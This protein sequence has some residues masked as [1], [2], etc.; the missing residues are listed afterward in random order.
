MS[1]RLVLALIAS[2]AALLGAAGSAS[3]QSNP[4]EP[5]GYLSQPFDPLPYLPPPPA[6]GSAAEAADVAAYRDALKYVGTERWAQAAADDPV[7]P[8]DVL[9]RYRCAIGV[10]LAPEDAPALVRAITRSYR[11]ADAAIRAAK[12]KYARPRPFKA[13]AAD[14][15]L[16][17]PLTETQRMNASPSYPSGHGSYGGLWGLMLMELAP[18]RAPQVM[19]RTLTFAE[20][21]V[22]CRVHYPSD[23]Q[24]A[25]LVAV[26]LYARLQAEPEF[27]ADMAEARREVDAARAAQAGTPEG[28]PTT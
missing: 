26:G 19:A 7:K 14:T 10:D 27:R 25:Q 16:C 21:R 17:L 6:A 3:T 18:D 2:A 1:R 28:C 20:S 22:V 24:A 12:T 15:P 8:A 23:L 5:L 9:R 11:D 4:L 13:D